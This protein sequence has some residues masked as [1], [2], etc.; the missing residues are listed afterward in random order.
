MAACEAALGPLIQCHGEQHPEV[1]DLRT[2]VGKIHCDQERYA[3]AAEQ[4]D[5]ALAIFAKQP[6][7]SRP[8]ERATLQLRMAELRARQNEWD[9]AAQGIANALAARTDIIGA[10]HPAVAEC[11]CHL[12]WVECKRGGDVDERQAH[13][14]R[15]AETD[16]LWTQMS[17]LKKE[18][19]FDA[20]RESTWFQALVDKAGSSCW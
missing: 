15:A 18:E 6:D 16:F 17:F 5:A 3:D 11:H 12:A 4:F 7:S 13:L 8:A 14:R 10:Q 2:L 20:V 19:A 9:A 1:A